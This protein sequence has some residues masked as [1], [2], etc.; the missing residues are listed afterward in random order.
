MPSNQN[1]KQ[2][3]NRFYMAI[4]RLLPSTH[5][6]T[7][8]VLVATA[9]ALECAEWVVSLKFEEIGKDALAKLDEIEKEAHAK[10][11]A[12]EKEAHAKLDE[13]EKEAQA[14]LDEM[15]AETQAE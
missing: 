4:L 11:D 14:K 5:A 10:L 13:I 6:P 8:V 2:T 7:V 9:C 1:T 15:K 12:I 3:A